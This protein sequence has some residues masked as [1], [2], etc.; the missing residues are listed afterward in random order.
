MKKMKMMLMLLAVTLVIPTAV[1]AEDTNVATYSELLSCVEEDNASCKLT[2]N[3]ELDAPLA[4]TKAVTLDLNG[5]T[6]SPKAGYTGNTSTGII[7]VNHGATL[8]I[9]DSGENG[10]IDGDY[11]ML[12]IQMS[13]PGDTDNAKKATLIVNDGIIKGDDYAIS[14]NGNSGRDNTAITINGGKLESN[15]TAI[16]QPQNGSLKVT[17]GTIIGAKTGIEVRSGSLEVTGGTITGNGVPDSSV[18]NGNGTTTVG[19]GVAIAQHT[20]VLNLSSTIKG[21]NINGYV[22]FY[23]STPQTNSDLT[24]ISISIE[25]GELSAINGGTVVVKSEDFTGF[26]TG[27]T[28]NKEVTAS[29]IKAGYEATEVTDGYKVAVIEPKTDIPE[30]DTEEE[31]EEIVVGANNSEENKQILVDSL[32]D[33]EELAAEIEGKDVTVLVDVFGVDQDRMD[34]ELLDEF[35]EAAKG[36]EIAD[37]F[38][39][40]IVVKET[41]N[42][43]TIGNLTS[44]NDAIELVVVLPEEFKNKDS[45]MERSYYV[46]RRHVDENQKVT[47][48]K[49]PATLSEDG[50]HVT[51]ESSEFSTYA[52]AYEDKA[53]AT[54][55]PQTSDGIFGSLFMGTISI[56]AFGYASLCLQKRKNVKAN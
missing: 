13:G 45:K 2:A 51:F 15:T 55:N 26:I 38:E 34:E 9:N 25:G 28:Y 16:Y 21:G 1:Y 27:G 56:I 37:Y 42:G 35:K 22:A 7:W 52:L 43:Q 17:G 53:V 4:L 33:N 12:A 18:A 48:T 44:L 46:I 24:K 3:I 8:T 40:E 41:Q 23:Q 50:T 39:V 36:L 54:K 19:A 10:T 49:I 32:K 6:I 14:G 30:I 11:F 47:Y 5:Y 20:T 29:Y 31:V